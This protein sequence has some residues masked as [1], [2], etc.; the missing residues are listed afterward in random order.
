MEFLDAA[1]VRE[2]L[3]P[4]ALV[5]ALR[6]AFARAEEVVVPDRVALPVDPAL[7][8][9][10]LL[11]PAWERDGLIAVK[12][13]THHPRNG[14]RGLPAIQAVVALADAVTGTPLTVL[15]GTELTR[16]RTAAASALAADYLA[17]QEVR[18]HLLIGAGNV[19]VAMPACSAAVRQVDHTR[20]WARRPEQ[21]HRL[22]E[23]LRSQ[24][25]AASA[26]EDL[27]AAVRTA[28]I[29]SAATSSTSP[30]VL[31]ADVR[32]GTHVD[33]AGAFTPEMVE[34]DEDLITRSRI[35]L[36]ID[37]AV[38]AG[39][40]TGPLERGTLTREQIVGTLS[41]LAAGRHTGRGSAEE[42]TVF[43]SMG[44]SLEDLVP[45]ALAWEAVGGSGDGTGTEG[46]TGAETEDGSGA[47]ARNGRTPAGGAP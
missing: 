17:P 12:V 21:A 43:K 3:R 47:G 4:A 8:S 15:D 30:L 40:L 33:L 32:P 1:R 2:L 11:K 16:L 44:T 28:D 10:L 45:A 19:T 7:G 41:D 18:E 13:L 35:F 9:S 25:Y 23:E 31:G 14:E 42:V 39:D 6:A 29:V 37:A 26:A 38:G 27:R 34:A 36:D 22:V 46:G 24:G 5:E 20:V